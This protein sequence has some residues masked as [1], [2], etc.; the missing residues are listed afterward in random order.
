[1]ELSDDTPDW[2]LGSFWAH[3]E[4]VLDPEARAATSGFARMDGAVVD[5]VV[6]AVR[7]DLESGAWDRRHGHLRTLRS[8]DVGLRLIISTPP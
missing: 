1:M 5:R 8:F 4:R 6:E 2:M 3:P 7:R